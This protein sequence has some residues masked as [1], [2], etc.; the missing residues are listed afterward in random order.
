MTR[1]A[2][3]APDPRSDLLWRIGWCLRTLVCRLRRDDVLLL[4]AFRKILTEDEYSYVA[5][6]DDGWVVIDGRFTSTDNGLTEEEIA[7]VRRACEI[8]RR[9]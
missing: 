7:A 8:G 2:I 4:S 9:Y 3:A 5:V 1:T 6:D